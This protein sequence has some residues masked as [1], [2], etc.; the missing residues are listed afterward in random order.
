VTELI[1]RVLLETT[2]RLGLY[3]CGQQ[4]PELNPQ[5]SHA[6]LEVD[7]LIVD[8][9]HDQFPK[10]GLTGWVF[11]SSSWHARFCDVERRDLCLN[12]RDWAEYPHRTYALL[13]HAVGNELTSA[14]L[15]CSRQRHSVEE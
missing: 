2:G 6:W 12:S 7:G 8:V 3:A 15:R 13:R 5:Q 11:E 9:T 4:H 10:T 14:G 1:G